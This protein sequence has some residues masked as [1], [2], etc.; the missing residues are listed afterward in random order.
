[1]RK[2]R[3]LGVVQHTDEAETDRY[4]AVLFRGN[5]P[6]VRQEYGV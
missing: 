1:V 5:K 2:L 3:D 4:E 6:T